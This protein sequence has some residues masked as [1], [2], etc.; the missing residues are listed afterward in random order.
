LKR[1]LIYAGAGLLVLALAA[2]VLWMSFPRLGKWYVRRRVVPKYEKL[3]GREIRIDDI[4]VDKRHIVLTGVS[5]RGKDDAANA[6]LLH[7]A[8]VS[9]DYDFWKA[10]K[11]DVRIG[12]LVVEEPVATLAVSA[13]G[14]DNW[15]DVIERWKARKKSEPPEDP[16]ARKASRFK[17]VTWS[18]GALH[19]EDVAHGLS[20]GIDDI[21]G[22]YDPLATFETTLTT[23]NAVTRLGPSAGAERVAVSAQ[24]S[25]L[26]G[27]LRVEVSG[28][29]VT[30][31]KGLALTGITG[32]VAPQDGSSARAVLDLQGG[33]GG[34]PD[35]LW[36]AKGWLDRAEQKGEMH[37]RADRFTFD[38]LAP[39]LEGGPLQKPEKTSLGASLDLVLAGDDLNVEGEIKL[40]GLTV[41][42][43]WVAPKPL[44]DLGFE[45]HIKGRYD[46]HARLFE[47]DALSVVFRGIE[48][49]LEGYVALPGGID[50]GGADPAGG[51]PTPPGPRLHPRLRARLVVPTVTC[52]KALKALPPAVTPKLQGFK[53]EGKFSTD[54][55]VDIDWG[56]LDALELGGSIGIY[57]CKV[58]EAPKSVDS[59]KL[60]TDF[61]HT[62]EVEKDKYLKFVIGPS[63]PDF[64]A[65]NDISPNI[66][67]SLLTTEDN[68]FFEHKGFIVSEFRTALIKDLQAGYFKYGAS[69]IT[70]QFVKNI[71]LNREKTVARKLQELF[72]TWY[73]EQTLDKERILE[74]YLNAI[75]FGPGLY[76]IGQAT[77]HYFGKHPRDIT[78]A[79]AAFFST[80]LPNPKKRHL[81]YC[82]NKLA[83]WAEAKIERI[84]KL[85]LDR[86]RITQAEYDASMPKTKD[87]PIVHFVYPADFDAKQC[88]KE[89]ERII[90]N[91]R[92]TQPTA[93]DLLD[94]DEATKPPPG[95]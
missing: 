77:Y 82:D 81:Q 75:E 36:N 34:V 80:I 16:R 3:L 37:V 93:E 95:E 44:A 5:V 29:R 89:T 43:P 35:V 88:R 59:E 2:L 11:G 46:R 21:T 91:S 9:A 60:K 56:N 41:F 52:Q 84:L 79:E 54:L 94:E 71:L 39:I 72:L 13:A 58:L 51:A 73:V 74:I 67:K 18:H 33:Y 87:D 19:L 62:V 50:A 70:M 23:L 24:A 64:V 63:N 27:T 8:R 92:P 7:V 6:P 31:Y 15:S 83:R 66:V 42:H 4:V 48:A 47:L 22:A 25:D 68:M 65:L 30:P 32:T 86:E 14:K 76:G 12:D 10:V 1:P 20:A 85:E 57:G 49:R 53:L 78:P 69:S 90:K 40:A 26:R 17:H 45:G 61:E 55:A 28:G 38:K